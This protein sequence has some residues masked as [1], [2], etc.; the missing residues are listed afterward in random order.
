[1]TRY[2][3]LAVI[4]PRLLT[5]SQN[6]PSRPTQLRDLRRPRS[7]LRRRLPNLGSPQRCTLFTAV[8]TDCLLMN[9]PPVSDYARVGAG[10]GRPRAVPAC[11]RERLRR[12]D[13]IDGSPSLSKK[14]RLRS[15]AAFTSL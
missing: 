12:S 4:G 14:A 2:M 5:P 7:H 13:Y 8:S 9:A 11:S 10:R 1:M 3:P 15:V 6:C